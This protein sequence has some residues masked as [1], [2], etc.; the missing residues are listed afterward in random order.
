MTSLQQTLAEA[1]SAGRTPGSE[2][3]G[4]LVSAFPD[5]ED[6]ALPAP[7]GQ[8]YSRH[9][10]HFTDSLEIMVARWSPGAACAPHDHGGSAG[11]VVVLSGSLTET[12][13]TW[14]GGDLVA[15]DSVVRLPGSARG[16]GPDVIH[17]MRAE[18]G[19]AV[20]LHVYSPQPERMFVYDLD[21]REVLDLV[22]DFGAWIPDGDHPR[23]A[24]AATA[25]AS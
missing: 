14:R 21:R 17:A 12:D 9:A 15:A 24:F 23:T 8:P 6:R 13:Y 10:L 11:F 20:T 1:A 19:G 4:R 25:L 18:A 2:L 5:A 16:F 3:V 7:A 22:G